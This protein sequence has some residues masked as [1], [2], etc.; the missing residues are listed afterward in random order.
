MYKSTAKIVVFLVVLALILSFTGILAAQSET[1]ELT[2]QDKVILTQPAVCFITSY[3]LGYVL[4]PW[5]NQWS[6]AY[7][8]AFV[9]TGFCVNP[10]TGHIIT[11]GHMVEISAAE[12]KYDLIYWYLTDTYIL[13][14]WSDSDWN[15]A[16]ENIKV[17][18]FDGGDYDLEVYVQFN[19]ANAGI[20]DD[21][22]S[23][24]SFVRAEVIDY[25][26]WEQRDI[27]L[28]K[29]QPQT[30]RALSA[31]M[32]GDSSSVEIQDPLT[33][34]GY[35]WSSDIGQANTMSPTVTNGT[36]S[37]KVMLA[38]TEVMQIQGSAREGNSGGPVLNEDGQVV[39]ILTMGTDYTNNYYR[40]SN[41]IMDILN[42]NGV[43]NKLGMVDE[44]F[45]QGLVNYR[46]DHHS[47]AIDHFNAV[48]NLN[49]RHLL[50]QDYRS[51]SQEAINRGEDIPVE[52]VAAATDEEAPET[53]EPVA[54]TDDTEVTGQD[55]E[56]S[57]LGLGIALVIVLFVVVPLVFIALI[58]VIIILVVKRKNKAPAAPA[59]APA[60]KE[61]KKA[62]KAKH[63]CP[64]CGAEVEKGAKF[65]GNCGN[66]IE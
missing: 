38:G 60:K 15:W 65:C 7:W 42:K 50:A 29:I 2:S 5:T 18:G 47:E 23:E 28:L 1:Y 37:G 61:A 53:A 21:P 8:E 52:D 9:G 46:L 22:T 64:N 49:Q 24:E 33:I 55:E 20:P 13:D 66:K 27:A 26:G 14:D 10:E 44:E 45:E 11:A 3:F 12:F 56:S 6:A 63:F 34:I 31:A 62:A 32:I 30:G 19:T 51:K 36:L 4:D 57:F 25:S 58:V 43:T 16:Y 39:G 40:P 17:E 48:L 41:D 35:P 54:D 59:A